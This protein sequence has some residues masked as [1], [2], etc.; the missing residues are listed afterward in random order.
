MTIDESK[1]RILELISGHNA[2]AKRFNDLEKCVTDLK[3]KIDK[4]H[5]ALID[6][7]T[8]LEKQ[9]DSGPVSVATFTKRVIR[10][11]TRVKRK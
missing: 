8:I 10:P 11:K 2:L 9:L 6:R 4:K 1:T 5:I 3:D 7:V